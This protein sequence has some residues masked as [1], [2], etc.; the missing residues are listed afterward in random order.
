MSTHAGHQPNP[1]RLRNRTEIPRAERDRER[2]TSDS[3]WA[4][5]GF[6][7][8]AGLIVLAAAVVAG[9]WEMTI[10]VIVLA[11]AVALFVGLHRVVALRK[12]E[13]R[14]GRLVDASADDASDPVPHL[15]PDAGDLGN[16]PQAPPGE[17][18]VPID[19]P[20]KGAVRRSGR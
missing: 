16:T 10:P 13:V 15:G 4:L 14:D 12:T 6:A 18:D 11:A 3:F 17:H 20:N 5:V 8:L 9:G 2:T 19:A 7:V 1:D